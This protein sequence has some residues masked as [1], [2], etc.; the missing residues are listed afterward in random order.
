MTAWYKFNKYY[1]LTDDTPVFTASVLLHPGLRESYLKAVW[2]KKNR[3]YIQ[4]AI[5]NVRELC[6]MHFKLQDPILTVDLDAIEDPVQRFLAEMTR[7]TAITEE[8]NDFI[9]V[10]VNT[11]KSPFS[12]NY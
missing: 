11:I 6:L 7:S 1:N 3:Q 5:K 4:P 2:V 12:A 10:G 9:K 8:F